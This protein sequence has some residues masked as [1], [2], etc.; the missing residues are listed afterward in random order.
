[1]RMVFMT[2]VVLFE[3]SSEIKA[4]PFI[5]FVES[6]VARGVA[7]YVMAPGFGGGVAAADFDDDG[8]IDLFLPTSE[9]TPDLLFR[10]LGGGTFEEVAASLG[11]ASTARS[12]VALW[13]DSDGDHLLDLL[14]ASDCR[15]L[16]S[17]DCTGSLL[18]LY[19]QQRD[20]TFVD[21]SAAAGLNT[22]GPTFD[23]NV[24]RGGIAAGDLNGDGFLDLV[25]A[26]WGGSGLTLLLNDGAGVFIDATVASGVGPAFEDAWQPILFD[27]NNDGL[28]DIF[29]TVD[30]LPNHLWINQGK[31]KFV[32]IAPRV[33][34]DIA[35][36]DMG[37]AIG[38]Y[39]NDGRFD[40]YVTEITELAHHNVLLRRDADPASSLFMEIA[41]QAGVADVGF[42]WGATFFDADN[43]G[44]LDLA[45]T[46]GWF[47][48]PGVNDQ[49]RFFHNLAGSQFEDLSTATGF[50]DTQWG[51]SL[52]AL[53]LDRD[54]DL[55]L[56]QTCNQG[57]PLRILANESTGAG[58]F[59][60][61]R[62]RMPGANHRAIGAVVHVTAG[63]LTMSRI[64]TAGMSFLGQE[65]AEAHFG[66]GIETIADRVEIA[67]PDGNITTLTAVPTNQLLTIE[68]GACC[69]P[70]DLDFN[71]VVDRRD[72]SQLMQSWGACTGVCSGD[73]D[74]DGDVD[75]ADLAQLLANWG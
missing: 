35:W 59:L 69:A 17:S 30:F 3:Q 28:L 49:S 46:N 24:H 62:P 34:V 63:G 10:N 12:R 58:N 27:A 45:V 50:N 70:G 22:V 66:V 13:F 5:Q 39:N 65:P 74:S 41:A 60:V 75:S 51:S 47:N 67:W 2:V 7:G 64:I 37:V 52:I 4:A 1:M 40:L 18:R 48:G 56:A 54:G 71:S 32:D 19:R 23:P 73:I 20:G 53:D 31:A 14:V 8:D 9:G 61:I 72:L 26:A 11:L 6:A 16:T 57:G 44:W 38:D 55:D 15:N 68:Q 42:A 21:V 29:T 43:D 25:L 36:N 33:G